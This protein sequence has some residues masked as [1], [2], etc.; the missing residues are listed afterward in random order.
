MGREQ[1]VRRRVR[2]FLRCTK[3][4]II[5]F[6]T[7][8]C[9]FYLRSFC[10]TKHQKKREQKREAGKV[11]LW[12]CA[13][14][15]ARL[16]SRFSFVRVSSATIKLFNRNLFESPKVTR[17][18]RPK[19]AKREWENP[20]KKNVEWRLGKTKFVLGLVVVIV[21]NAAAAAAALLWCLSYYAQVL[22][23]KWNE[24]QVHSTAA[25]DVRL[26]LEVGVPA[27]LAP[28]TPATAKPP[29][30]HSS[31]RCCCCWLCYIKHFNGKV[32]Q[33]KALFQ[34]IF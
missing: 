33:L 30:F 17:T 3:S 16:L 5:K 14:A 26:V 6:A 11:S 12:F 13:I 8:F 9:I 2:R 34:M 29:T 22:F 21:A 25:V 19:K 1:E 28:A 15:F 10:P 7:P 20:K 23:S 18:W 31:R 27:T 4:N 24:F 32:S